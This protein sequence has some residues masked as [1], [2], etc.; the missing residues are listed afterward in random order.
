MTRKLRS[1]HREEEEE[2]EEEEDD[3]YGLSV[4]KSRFLFP[5]FPIDGFFQHLLETLPGGNDR[6]ADVYIARELFGLELLFQPKSL[7]AFPP[8]FADLY[9]FMF[10]SLFFKLWEGFDVL[11][12]LLTTCVIRV[13][14]CFLLGGYVD[15]LLAV[16]P[17][18]FFFSFLFRNFYVCGI[19]VGWSFT[20]LY[21]L[22]THRPS[23]SPKT[24]EFLDTLYPLIEMATF[25]EFAVR[26]IK[27]AY[28]W[29]IPRPTWVSNNNTS[30]CP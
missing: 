2:E 27:R 15:S 11:E 12:Q 1:Q 4:V 8:F 13:N 17:F 23:H 5:G 9:L 26:V 14:L 25:I 6:H 16:R 19:L 20:L 28:T 24:A 3:Q 22:I 21:T 7:K 29:N 30:I 10:G 18:S